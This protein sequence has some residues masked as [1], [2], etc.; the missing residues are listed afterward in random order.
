V[1]VVRTKTRKLGIL[2]IWED[3]DSHRLENPP[4]SRLRRAGR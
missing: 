3:A 1:V 2:G 4:S